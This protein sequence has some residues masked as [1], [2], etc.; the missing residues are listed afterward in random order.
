[1]TFWGENYGFVKDVYEYRIAKYS[2]W[3]DNLENIVSKVLQPNV[4]Y[5]FKEFKNIKDTLAVSI[6]E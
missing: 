2:E 6:K 3:M 1:M 4:Q 5:T